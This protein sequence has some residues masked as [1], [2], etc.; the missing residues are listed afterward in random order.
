MTGKSED[1]GA[2]D[3]TAWSLGELEAM[4][5]EQVRLLKDQ[6]PKTDEQRPA[7]VRRLKDLI[8]AARMLAVAKAAMARA[9]A[10]VLR[11]VSDGDDQA[12]SRA[13]RAG[14]KQERDEFRADDHDLERRQAAINAR[15]AAMAAEADAERAGRTDDAGRG[16]GAGALLG[17]AGAQASAG[18]R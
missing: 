16:D 13:V 11:A 10:A 7:Y 4:L 3:L 17:G 12:I 18:A 2:V 9:T 14:L 5:A 15:F 8:V 6:K 1:G